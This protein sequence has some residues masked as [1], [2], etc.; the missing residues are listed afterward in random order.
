MLAVFCFSCAESPSA[1][2][3]AADKGLCI[4]SWNVQA[5]F[6]GD[7]SGTEYEEYR[8]SAGWTAEKY[9]ARLNIMAKAILDNDVPDVLA[10]IEVE[11]QAALKH[12]AQAYLG[13]AGYGYSF[14]AANPGYSLGVGVLSRYPFTKTMVHQSV[15]DGQVLPR[16]IA[17]VWLE[18]GGSP[19][20]IFICHWKSKLG[21]DDVTEVQ[22]MNAAQVILR[23]QQELRRDYP[24]M[25]MIVLGD[26]NEN[27]DEFVR[28]GSQTVCA[29]MPDTATAAAVAADA[30]AYAAAHGVTAA[31]TAPRS[32]QFLV[33]SG[34]KPPR[35]Q[36][37]DDSSAVF[38]SP[39]THELDNGSY[40]YSKQWE[41]IDHFLL[42]TQLFDGQGWDFQGAFV[43]DKEPFTTAK[44][45]PSP[46]TPR[47]GAGLSDH[48]PIAVKLSK[49]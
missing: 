7:D 25:P 46:Y 15:L 30:A 21:G 41:T 23:R 31:V 5:L 38:Y 29:L 1:D 33:L 8:E 40:Y 26:L 28:R 49:Q 24:D 47:T 34:E 18:P 22:R 36:F 6:D 19:I 16:P 10:L 32:R 2:K 35:T 45:L 12:F 9:D 17:E 48:L 27:H 11:N 4:M 39:W 3:A 44:G 42:S 20:A 37:F 43:V 14:F 13:Q